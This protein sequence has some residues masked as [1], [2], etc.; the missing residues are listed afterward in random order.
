MDCRAGY[1]Q[2]LR[3]AAVSESNERLRIAFR[4]IPNVLWEADIRTGTYNIYNVEDQMCRPETEITGF[5]D[6]FL[7]K[8][9]IHP[10]SEENFRVFASNMMDGKRA[11]AGSFIMRDTANNCYGW[12]SMSCHMMYDRDG[13]PVKAV[14]VQA[15][16]PSMSGI[17][18]GIFPRRPLPEVVRHHLIVRT[19]ISEKEE[20]NRRKAVAAALSLSLGVDCVIGQYRPDIFFVFFPR[21]ENRFDLKRRIEDAFAYTR[22]SM[23][24]IHCIEPVQDGTHYGHLY[25]DCHGLRVRPPEDRSDG[26]SGSRSGKRT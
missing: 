4:Q 13:A 23:N 24:D 2:A 15:N 26:E 3:S 5:P 1:E 20:N 14:G 9:I 21:V 19:K 17:A 10:D 25:G 16:L 8:G 7:E 18:P 12:V 6:A 11:D 22:V